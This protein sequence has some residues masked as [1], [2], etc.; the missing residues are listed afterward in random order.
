MEKRDYAKEF[1]GFG[2]G[3]REKSDSAGIQSS[4]GQDNEREE[5]K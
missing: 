4:G 3:E 2:K 1:S 5:E